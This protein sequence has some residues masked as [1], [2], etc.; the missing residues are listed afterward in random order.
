MG[1]VDEAPDFWLSAHSDSSIASAGASLDASLGAASLGAASGAHDAKLGAAD[2]AL[3]AAATTADNT[4]TAAANGIT[5]GL[6]TRLI[7][8]WLSKP[9]SSPR[10]VPSG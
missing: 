3:E 1:A 6:K 4:F 9:P 10:R 7:T 8:N 2:G 5:G